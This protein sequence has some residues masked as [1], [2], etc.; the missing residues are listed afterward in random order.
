MRG[1][2]AA[3]ASP[4]R[5]RRLAHELRPQPR[6]ADGRRALPRARQR[7]GRVPASSIVG[8][9]R[10]DAR[11]RPLRP[12][13]VHASLR[14]RMIDALRRDGARTI[15][16]DLVFDTKTDN[17]DDLA[18]LRRRER[19]IAATLVLAADATARQRRHVRAR[20]RRQPA[21]RRASGRQRELRHRQRRHDH[22][23]R[24]PEPL[25]RRSELRRRA[26]ARSAGR[27][28]PSRAAS[29]VRWR[30]AVD[31]LP[32]AGRHR[33]AVLVR[34]RA[35]RPRFDGAPVRGQDRRRR[36]DR[37]AISRTS[38]RSAADPRSHEGPELEADAISTLMTGAP[39]RSASAAART[40]SLLALAALSCRRSPAPRLRWPWLD[41]RRRARRGGGAA[42]RRAARVRRR[43]RSPCSS[44]AACRAARRRRRRC[45]RP[46][47]DRAPRAR[48][49]C[50]RRFARFDPSVVDAVLADPGIAL[51]VR[52]HGDR[53]GV[54]DR[55]LPARRR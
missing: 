18:A 12:L 14:R 9:R 26:A 55:R 35:R 31:R 5:L 43:R 19:A 38:T 4:L 32:R 29:A 33:A 13:S 36:H 25:A 30:L 50:A 20:R 44:R 17:Y 23:R 37:H 15:A 7:S 2:G 46:A 11:V 40:G 41:P 47:G 42:R 3:R 34:R 52:A 48:A 28:A 53:P 1:G 49:T 27:V 24:I 51:R 6:A 54:G 8:D 16:F 22:A 10:D 21:R 39:L 45:P